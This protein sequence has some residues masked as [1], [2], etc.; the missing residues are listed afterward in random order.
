MQIVNV[1]L[2]VRFVDSVSGFH[3]QLE[4]LYIKTM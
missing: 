2:A 1:N 4:S 3:N